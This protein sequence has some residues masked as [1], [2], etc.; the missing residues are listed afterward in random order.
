[1]DK[2]LLPQAADLRKQFPVASGV[3]A[4]FP[5]ALVLLSHVS[6]KGN[7]QHNPGQPLHWAREKSTDQMDAAVRHFME[8]LTH[9][10]P[11]SEEACYALA[12]CAWRV[13]AEL[14]LR[15]EKQEQK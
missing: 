10:N 5:N 11:Y 15:I 6:F 4:Y 1:M 2:P 13:L 7:E 3:L 9:A 12:Q 8:A 14:Q